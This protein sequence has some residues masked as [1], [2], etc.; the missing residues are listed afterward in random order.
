MNRW[1]S[2]ESVPA[3]SAWTDL[4]LQTCQRCAT[5]RRIYRP[6][7]C[8]EFEVCFPCASVLVN[9]GYTNVDRDEHYRGKNYDDDGIIHPPMRVRSV[10]AVESSRARR[11][12]QRRTLYGVGRGVGR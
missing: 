1:Y 9:N 8:P 12:R 4:G 3:N 11:E 2:L 6:E 5:W 7:A 10:G